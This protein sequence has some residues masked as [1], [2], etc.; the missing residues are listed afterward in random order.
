MVILNRVMNILILL[1]AIAAVVF[2]YL[3]SASGRNW[4]TGGRR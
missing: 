2:S 3:L 1:A 4:L